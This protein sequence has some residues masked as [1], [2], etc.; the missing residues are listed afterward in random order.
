MNLTPAPYGFKK[1]DTPACFRLTT[2]GSAHCCGGC[3]HAAENH[4]EVHGH[5]ASC[6]ARV[7]ARKQEFGYDPDSG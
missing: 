5:S 3:L 4:Y 6:D 1:C 2:T 7:V